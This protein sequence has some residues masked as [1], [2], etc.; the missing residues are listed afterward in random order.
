LEF[1]KDQVLQDL[2]SEGR[3]SNA[4]LSDLLIALSAQS[5]GCSTAMTFDK[6]ASKFPFFRLLT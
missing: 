4:D 5:C 6:K 3:K 2:L 1:E